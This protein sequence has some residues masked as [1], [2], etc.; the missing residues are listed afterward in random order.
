MSNTTL[1]MQKIKRI[2]NFS[3]FLQKQYRIFRRWLHVKK[4]LYDIWVSQ[5]DFKKGRY[6]PIETLFELQHLSNRE[7][8]KRFREAQKTNLPI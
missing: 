4:D 7:V 5:R 3:N 2:K 1:P 8:R 6:L